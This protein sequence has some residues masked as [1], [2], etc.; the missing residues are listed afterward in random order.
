M[1][2]GLFDKLE[3]YSTLDDSSLSLFLVDCAFGRM[4]DTNY[5][6]LSDL[7]EC[8]VRKLTEER[9]LRHFK[10]YITKYD[11]TSNLHEHSSH[12]F[13]IEDKSKWSIKSIEESAFIKEKEVIKPIDREHNYDQSEDAQLDEEMNLIFNN[14]ITEPFLHDFPLTSNTFQAIDKAPFLLDNSQIIIP[15]TQQ[16]NIVL[17]SKNKKKNHKSVNRCRRIL[18]KV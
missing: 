14:F 2:L 18:P 1:F 17:K 13:D 3:Q 5:I 9:I 10:Y 7:P 8:R 16:L 4:S 15:E 11:G 6:K 12:L